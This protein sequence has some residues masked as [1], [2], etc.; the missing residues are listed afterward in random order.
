MPPAIVKPA[1]RSLIVAPR[2]PDPPKNRGRGPWDADGDVI[3][4]CQIPGCPYD[5]HA[6]GPRAQVEL[7][8]REHVRMCHSQAAGPLVFGIN[9][10]R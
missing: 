6:I 4:D 2:L 5:W 8:R 7:A 3:V 10:P 1:A 9:T